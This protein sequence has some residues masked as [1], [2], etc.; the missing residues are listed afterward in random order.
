MIER[1]A[2]YFQ[3]IVLQCQGNDVDFGWCGGHFAKLIMVENPSM[4]TRWSDTYVTVKNQLASTGDMDAF[5]AF[6][7]VRGI[8]MMGR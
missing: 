2:L 1:D 4:M 6:L 7:L 8:A 3:H 5:Y